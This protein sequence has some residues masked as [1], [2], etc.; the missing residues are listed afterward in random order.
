MRIAALDIGDVRIG[1]AL[2]DAGGTIAGGQQSFRCTGDRARDAETV[3][4]TLLA[5]EAERIVV[6]L[7]L[8]MNG[9]EGP[10]AQK[11]RLFAKELARHTTSDI[12]FFDERL[13]T[14]QAR[15]VLIDA[16]V[17][18]KKRKTVIDKMAAQL[19]LQAYL[20]AKGGEGNGRSGERDQSHADQGRGS[21]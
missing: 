5:L 11:A 21:C 7:P 14:A 15:R 17:S 19:I 6:G 13:T 8:N 9:T 4:K 10:S 16:N 12:V 18:R 1:I 2:S 3:A 20:D